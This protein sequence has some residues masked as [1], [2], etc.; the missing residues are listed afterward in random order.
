MSSFTEDEIAAELN[1]RRNAIEN[2]DAENLENMRRAERIGCDTVCLS[3]GT[4]VK[5]YVVSDP[6]NPLCDT[7]LGN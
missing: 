2:R 7:C 4:P 6:A 1:R 3:C 5:S